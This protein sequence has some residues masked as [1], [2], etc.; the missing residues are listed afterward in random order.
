MKRNLI[1]AF[2]WSAALFATTACMDNYEELPV[3]Q[4]TEDFLFSRTDSVGDRALGFLGTIYDALESGHS[5]VGGYYLDAAS[6]DALPIDMDG[7]PDVL[8]LQLGQFTAHT[9]ITSEMKWGDYYSLI[10]KVNIFINGIDVV[11][12]KDTYIDAL[13]EEQPLN[14]TLKAEA[15]FIRAWFYFQMLERYGGVPLLGD[16]VYD[17]NDNLELPRNSFS[18]CGLYCE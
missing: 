1:M 12:F 2:A 16:K 7:E 3:D 14:R 4:Y 13:G 5:R 6:D 18:E 15:R 9:R 10:R 11:P 8:K 17:I